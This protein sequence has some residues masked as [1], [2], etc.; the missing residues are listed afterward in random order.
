M[1]SS[2]FLVKSNR[3]LLFLSLYNGHLSGFVLR[4]IDVIR[5]EQN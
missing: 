2:L 1:I 4:D 5:Q 3:V